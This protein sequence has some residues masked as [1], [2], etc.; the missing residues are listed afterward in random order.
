[1]KSVRS[2]WLRCAAAVGAACLAA[3]P[4]F[5]HHSYADFDRC[6][7]VSI[8]GEVQSVLWAN[9]HIVIHLKTD[10][11]KTYRIEWFTLGQLA[12]ASLTTQTVSVGDRLIVNG[13]EHRDP[14]LSLVSLLA[15]I[16]RPSDG[17]TWSRHRP[18]VCGPAV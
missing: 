17:W 3:E 7:S 2:P 15:R 11:A 12:Q 5:A 1:M 8:E 13:S 6:Q 16:H 9:P 10:D 4:T 14:S 18:P